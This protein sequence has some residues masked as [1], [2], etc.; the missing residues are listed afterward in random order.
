MSAFSATTAGVVESLEQM[1]IQGRG[2]DAANEY[3]IAAQRVQDLLSSLPNL[4]LEQL[5]S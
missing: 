1:G 4:T 5:R 2:A 3:S